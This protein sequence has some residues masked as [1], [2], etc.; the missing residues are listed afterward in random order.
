MFLERSPVTDVINNKMLTHLKRYLVIGGMPAAVSTYVETGNVG[1]VS[2]IQDNIIRQYKV[3]FTKYEAEDKKLMLTAIFDQIPSQLLRQNKR[4][5]YSDIQKKLRFEK[6]EDSFLWLK[7]AGVAIA[8]INATEPRIALSQNAKSSLI[9]L[10]SS[11]VGL[12]TYQYGNA[13]RAKVLLEKKRLILVEFMRIL[14]HRS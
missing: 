10:Y 11:D 4:F 8:T 5:N 7:Y 12:L 1:E 2:I 9:K 14:L 6:L 13:L 3:D